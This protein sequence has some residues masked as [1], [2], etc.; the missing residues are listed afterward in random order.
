MKLFSPTLALAADVLDDIERVRIANENRLRQLTRPA[1]E[2]DADGGMRGFGLTVE[3]PDVARLAAMVATLGQVEKDATKNLEKVMKDHPLGPWV[4]GA[5]GV[6]LKQGA[7]L[8]AAI[9]DPY[10]NT[11]HDRPRT[12]SE[13]WAYCG[14]SVINGRAQ[15]RA[16]GEKANW[17][18]DAKMRTYLVAASCIKQT[19]SPYRAV[20]DEFRARY[21]DATHPVEC[22]R[23]GP[24]G[25]PAQTGTPLSS[26]HQHAR[27]LRASGKAVLRDLWIEA[28]RIHQEGL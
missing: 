5:V 15:A 26:G 23:C 12:V 21:A 24:S 2:V 19:S 25:K 4:K 27:S 17:S 20:Y 11:L 28:R 1:D 16:R 14:Y 22:R 13:L 18:A 10:W 8:I 3:H 7:R 6:G 9:G